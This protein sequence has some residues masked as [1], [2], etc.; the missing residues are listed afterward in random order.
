M[1]LLLTF[2]HLCHIITDKRKKFLV[3]KLIK[4][5]NI[6]DKKINL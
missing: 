4:D 3:I 6:V 2:E 1:Y 5:Q